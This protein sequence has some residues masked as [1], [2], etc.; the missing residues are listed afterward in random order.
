M[1]RI[2]II[3]GIPHSLAEFGR[4]L[5]ACRR[6]EGLSQTELAE[7]IYGSLQHH[8]V[9]LASNNSRTG[10]VMIGRI[11]KGLHHPSEEYFEAIKEVLNLDNYNEKYFS[12]VLIEDIKGQL[13]EIVETIPPRS[14]ESLLRIA[15][16]IKNGE[17]TN[18]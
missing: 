2:Y 1:E 11:E 10:G 8:N 7:K 9:T 12:D 5:K 15:H 13:S 16:M 6:K 3:N 17:L 18:I 4:L 14:A